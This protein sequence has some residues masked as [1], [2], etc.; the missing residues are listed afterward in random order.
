MAQITLTADS[1]PAFL[2]KNYLGRDSHN[3]GDLVVSSS[4]SLKNRLYDMDPTGQW[5]S[6]GSND[7]TSEIITA[8]LYEGEAQASRSIDFI[9]LMNINLKNF[10][11]EYSANNG[12]SYATITGFDYQ[13]GTAD[14][15]SSNIITSLVSPISANKL[16][17]TMYRTQTA[18][19]EKKIGLVVFALGTHQ[20]TTHLSAYAPTRPNTTKEARMADGSISYMHVYRSDNS[21]ELYRASVGWRFVS[22]SDRTTFRSIKNSA[23]PFLWYPEPGDQVRDIFLCRI[24]PGSFNDPFATTYKGAGYDISMAL[25]EIGGA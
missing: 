9:A 16:K 20:T 3:A 6:S 18:N 10:L 11:L 19:Q 24:V 13:I 5:Q 23:A 14:Y 1:K 7:A 17:L 8:G 4:D 22:E 12:S 15:A 25:E 21:F 2:S